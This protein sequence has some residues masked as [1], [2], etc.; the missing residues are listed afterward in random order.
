M[1]PFSRVTALVP[2][3][4]LLAAKLALTFEP[5]AGAGAPARTTG[6][7]RRNDGRTCDS[8]VPPTKPITSAATPNP[9]PAAA[10]D[11]SLI[12]VVPST[13]TEYTFADRPTFLFYIP[14]TAAK[15]AEFSLEDGTQQ[16]TSIQIPLTGKSGI[17]SLTPDKTSPV[18]EVDRD[19]TWVFSLQCGNYVNDPIV[20][21]TVRRIQPDAT[22][23]SRISKAAPLEK[24]SL[25]A[26]S[27]IWYDAISHLAMLRRAQPND[28]KLVTAWQELLQSVGL[29]AI[30]SVPLK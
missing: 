3:D 9:T 4:Q 27:G 8:P 11:Q 10:M 29:G 14:E 2:S 23:T 5:R 19:Y 17:I 26:T 16:V 12:A 6:G 7:G 21:G 15:V 20:R 22:L 25:Y 1:N 28:P 24:V 30:A 18:L 13:D